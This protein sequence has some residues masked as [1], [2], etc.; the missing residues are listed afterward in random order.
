MFSILFVEKVADRIYI[1]FEN[2]I[3]PFDA[4]RLKTTISGILKSA[5]DK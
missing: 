2:T 4:S 1:S 3:I 5:N